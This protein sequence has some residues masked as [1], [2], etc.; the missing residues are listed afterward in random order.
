MTPGFD[1][2]VAAYFMS[3]RGAVDEGDLAEQIQT[4]LDE[5]ETLLW[6]DKFSDK[7]LIGGFGKILMIFTLLVNLTIL[8]LIF[9]PS[10]L[11]EAGAM[12]WLM[13]PLLIVDGI[14][15]LFILLYFAFGLMTGGLNAIT[16]QRVLVA[17]L[18]KNKIVRSMRLDALSS[19]RVQP[20]GQSRGSITFYRDESADTRASAAQPR[21]MSLSGIRN[22]S[23]VVNLL[24]EQTDALHHSSTER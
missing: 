10:L 20:E 21:R 22:F 15:L 18:H 7:S 4:L 1:G 11:P 6:W 8:I 14:C 5:G 12:G 13:I 2:E 3:T 16:D 17:D 9:A 24:R 23:R 19:I